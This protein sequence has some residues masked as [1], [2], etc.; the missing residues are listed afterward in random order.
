MA[1]TVTYL[2]NQ[3]KVFGLLPHYFC[4]IENQWCRGHVTLCPEPGWI[5]YRRVC[6]DIVPEELDSVM[7]QSYSQ[8]LLR[9]G[10]VRAFYGIE[11]EFDRY[12][13]RLKHKMG[14][15]DAVDLGPMNVAISSGE[16]SQCKAGADSV[17]LQPENAYN[18]IML[19]QKPKWTT[20]PRPVDETLV[21]KLNSAADDIG[22]V[23]SN[24]PMRR[25]FS[26]NINPSADKL[27]NVNTAFH[28]VPSHLSHD[29]QSELHSS[30][31]KNLVTAF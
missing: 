19:R 7:Q 11:R 14:M 23:A 15:I 4:S 21:S 13:T 29:S 26:K 25:N 8:T 9:I 1:N 22:L 6:T 2:A 12:Y 17:F 10:H 27:K 20:I 3:L 24:L 18:E 30:N 31:H 5:D 16:D 28:R